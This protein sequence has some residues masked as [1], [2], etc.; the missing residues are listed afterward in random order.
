MSDF[1][2]PYLPPEA[3]EHVRKWSAEGYEAVVWP[4]GKR[5]FA[6]CKNCQDEGNVLVSYLGRGPFKY[7]P[8]ETKK[9]KWVDCE[10]MPR[11]WYM[12]ERTIGYVCPECGGHRIES[13]ATK[14]AREKRKA[15]S[16]MRSITNEWA[17]SRQE[18]ELPEWLQEA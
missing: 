16:K 11:G 17:Q 3:E 13:V 6:K 2:S 5:E 4:Y 14:S 9:V 8:S 10:G 1:V 7:L 12:V 18:D 15:V